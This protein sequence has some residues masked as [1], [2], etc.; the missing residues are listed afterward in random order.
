M[1]RRDIK[2][3]NIL[4]E[5]N[6]EVGRGLKLADFGSCRGIYSKQPYTEYISTRW[7]RA[8]ECLLTDG[9]YG[10]EMDLWG[11]GCVMFEITSLY[12]LF[13][14]SNE[15]DQITRI[16]KVLGTPSQEL[17]GKFKTKGSTHISLDFPEQ[18]GIG[19][20]NLIPHASPDSIDL[21][22]KMLR[23]DASER[24]TSREAIRHPY[25]R[26]VREAE[27]K[28]SDLEQSGGQIG[29][30]TLKQSSNDMGS[31]GKPVSKAIQMQSTLASAVDKSLPS[32][33][34]VSTQ[35]LKPNNTQTIL[36][37]LA[38]QSK[39]VATNPTYN[40]NGKSICHMYHTYI[41]CNKDDVIVSNS[42]P[43]I[44]NSG[45]N[46]NV[47]KIDKSSLKT[48]QTNPSKKK[49]KTSIGNGVDNRSSRRVGQ[50]QE[51]VMKAYGVPKGFGA[52]SNSDTK[53]DSKLGGAARNMGIR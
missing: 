20:P 25:F 30:S 34:G 10:P 41:S 50:M 29:A 46:L 52:A 1:L 4:I 2:P 28:K 43:P 42:L 15:V 5:S 12:P 11:A 23:Y 39:A 13:P 16:H 53:I 8:P 17:L 3:E 31:P 32:L 51:Q 26:E 45:G 19:I 33:T 21:I 35:Q 9:Y 7:Y 36:N 48:S 6:T 47:K 18:K 27:A 37:K 14:G 44:A 49:R 22:V 38:Q 24:I 40:S